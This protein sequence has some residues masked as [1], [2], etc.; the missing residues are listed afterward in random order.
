MDVYI[1]IETVPDQTRGPDDY[2]DL[3]KVPA[4]YKDPNKI[5]DYQKQHAEEAWRKT[6]L[7]PNWGQIW[8]I[9]W[10][11]P[12]FSDAVQY[13]SHDEEGALIADF[14][15]HVSD[16]C[17]GRMP[18]WIGHNV[19]FDLGF[20]ARRAMVNRVKSPWVI[21]HTAAPWAGR[22]IDTMYQWGGAQEKIKLKELC[23]ILGVDVDDDDIDG[24]EVWDAI[25][26][27]NGDKVIE[28]C[29]KDVERVYQVRQ[30]M[31]G[32]W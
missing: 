10:K 29:V 24:S 25:Q 4:N 13:T 20:L 6:A 21:P 7:S 8:C 5:L 22:Y 15:A 18:T 12:D 19:Q 1:D 32:K 27:G 26:A 9:A 23:K 17:N 2:V 3:V 14:F 30:I 31:E 28:H 11:I 16:M